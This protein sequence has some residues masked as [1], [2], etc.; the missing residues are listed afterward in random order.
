MKVQVPCFL[1]EDLSYFVIISLNSSWN[2]KV[3]DKICGGKTNIYF[4]ENCAFTR[5]IQKES[6]SQIGHDNLAEC[7]T[8]KQSLHVM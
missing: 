3:S 2:E 6:Q 5:Q 7:G 8:K 4:P 1:Y